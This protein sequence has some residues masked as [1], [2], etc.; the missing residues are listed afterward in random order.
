M[1]QIECKKDTTLQD[2]KVFCIDV[3]NVTQEEAADII[4]AVTVQFEEKQIG[5]I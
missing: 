3:G 4:A 2:R 1:S 5:S